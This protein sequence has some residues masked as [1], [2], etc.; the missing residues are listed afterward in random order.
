MNFE[1]YK[2]ERYFRFLEV[3]NLVGKINMIKMN[4]INIECSKF[5]VNYK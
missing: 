4:L 1:E 5:I 3:R 2:E